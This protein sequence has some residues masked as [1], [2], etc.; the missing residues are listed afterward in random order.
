MFGIDGNVFIVWS[1]FIG[2]EC[3]LFIACNNLFVSEL[4]FHVMA[5][6]R[7]GRNTIDVTHSHLSPG[8]ICLVNILITPSDSN[9]LFS[10]LFPSLAIIWFRYRWIPF[11]YVYS[12][13]K[14]PEMAL[15]AIWLQLFAVFHPNLFP[16][17]KSISN[18]I[19]EI[20]WNYLVFFHDGYSFSKY[21]TRTH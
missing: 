15:P 5:Y 3:H 1:I 4:T 2:T 12:F 8:W 16:I 7:F 11:V 20:S 19:F 21:A 6:G 9:R 17:W 18:S 10:S 13:I 14:Y